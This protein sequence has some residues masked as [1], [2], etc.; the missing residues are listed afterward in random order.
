MQSKYVTSVE[1]RKYPS[2]YYGRLVNYKPINECPVKWRI[3]Y[4]DLNMIYLIADDYVENKYLA[5][6]GLLT[7]GS[8]G[9]Y[10]DESRDD[11]ISRLRE[12]KYYKGFIDKDNVAAHACGAL[13][14][15]EFASSYSTLYERVNEDYDREGKL[16]SKTFSLN[17][18]GFFFYIGR[19]EYSY[20]VNLNINDDL[21]IK[22][23]KNK[24][25]S[26]MWIASYSA[27]GNNCVM[28]VRYDGKV[29]GNAFTNLMCGLR[30]II[31]LGSN[32]KLKLN[33]EG[34]FDIIKE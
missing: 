34:T 17:C 3:I 19:G 4:S 26:R 22:D 25:I 13:T 24:G 29:M 9:V 5:D 30:P 7:S 32:T 10:S 8:Y 2:K 15:L 1:V 27:S 18:D 21:Y 11:L 12:D 14:M 6:T 33:S 28:T 23:C 16:F 31:L 20:H